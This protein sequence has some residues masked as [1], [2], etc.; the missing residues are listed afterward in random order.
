MNDECF[1][2][3]LI[4]IMHA[5]LL[6]DFVNLV[7]GYNLKSNEDV[8]MQ[9][10]IASGNIIL[11]IFDNCNNN[12][13]NG[14]IFS[15]NNIIDDN[16]EITYIDINDAY[17]KYKNDNNYNNLILIGAL[18]KSNNENEKIHIINLLFDGKMKKI[19]RRNFL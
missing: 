18:L 9:Y 16:N 1:R 12:R 17:K 10:K 13:F 19:I 6:N 4:D 8:Y 3:A 5:G 14:Y 11:N 15:N 7:F 2:L